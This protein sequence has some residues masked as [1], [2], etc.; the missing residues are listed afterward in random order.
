MAIDERIYHRYA[1][2]EQCFEKIKEAK[3]NSKYALHIKEDVVES[4]YWR[5]VSEGVDIGFVIC[6]QMFEKELEIHE[7]ELK[8]E[9][10]KTEEAEM[11]YRYR[12]W[13]S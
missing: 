10:E 5:G 13:K 9:Q 4:E 6:M 8:L 12:F 3:R 7:Q 2:A 1:A 11:K